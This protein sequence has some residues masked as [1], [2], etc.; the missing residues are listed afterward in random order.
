VLAVLPVTGMVLPGRQPDHEFR[1][2]K[3][4]NGLPYNKSRT[5]DDQRYTSLGFIKRMPMPEKAVIEKR[6][7]MVADDYHQGIIVYTQRTQLLH[8]LTDRPISIGNRV[9]VGCLKPLTILGPDSGAWYRPVINQCR[10]G[11]MGVGKM[12]GL[13]VYIEKLGTCPVQHFTLLLERLH[14]ACLTQTQTARIG[15][16]I[17]PVINSRLRS[18]LYD[19]VRLKIALS[20]LV[21]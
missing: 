11:R 19:R 21:V 18:L 1:Q 5:V 13:Q 3:M 4:A 17:Y 7:P 6:F 12:C 14:H 10:H 15:T 2:V 20:V 9:P 16:G 8:D